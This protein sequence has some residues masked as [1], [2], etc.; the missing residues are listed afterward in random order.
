M[1]FEPCDCQEAGCFRCAQGF[2]ISS[3]G[4]SPD[5]DCFSSRGPP[6]ANRCGRMYPD[7]ASAFERCV[8]PYSEWAKRRA[9]RSGL[10]AHFQSVPQ[11]AVEVDSCDDLTSTEVSQSFAVIALQDLEFA[12]AEL[13]TDAY[14][15]PVSYDAAAI[16]VARQI[17]KNGTVPVAL[18]A[19]ATDV[20]TATTKRPGVKG[21]IAGATAARDKL[22]HALTRDLIASLSLKATSSDRANGQSA[23]HAVATAFALLGLEPKSYQAIEKIWGNEAL[24]EFTLSDD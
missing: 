12:A 10:V 14:V 17:G 3:L 5:C 4:F 13:A 23:C 21:K 9:A 24:S 19:W 20:L 11:N 18:R 7:W 1:R 15:D 8:A 6:C 2:V 22:I 16:I